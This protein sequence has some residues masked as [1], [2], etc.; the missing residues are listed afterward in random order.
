MDESSNKSIIVPSHMKKLYE[1]AMKLYD[2][3][4]ALEIVRNI[5]D[6]VSGFDDDSLATMD[7]EEQKRRFAADQMTDA[8]NLECVPC[9]IKVDRYGLVHRHVLNISELKNGACN[10]CK[11]PIVLEWRMV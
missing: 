11:T 5:C 1:S 6:N 2:E 10:T 3:A 8:M 9:S 7:A 4:Q